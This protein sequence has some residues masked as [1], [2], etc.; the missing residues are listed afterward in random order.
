[1]IFIASLFVVS[2]G[3]DATG[4]T[5]W[6]GQALIARAGQSRTRLLVLMMLL[7]AVLTAL[8]SVNGAVAALLPVVAVM[9][10][11]LRMSPSQIL[12][13]LAFG[14]HAGSLV[15]LTGSPVNVIV[16]EYADDAG[17]GR[18]G[19]FEFAFV[20]IPLL[21][22]TI[23]IVVLFGERLLP[24]RKPRAMKRDFGDFARTLVDQYAL[25]DDP[26][27]LV[28]RQSGVA[29]VVVPPR[30]LLIGETVFPGMVTESGDL[31]V[32]A[33]QRKGEERSG[34][35][36]LAVGDTLLLQGSW[37]ALEYHLDD[38]DVLVVDDPAL[39][40]RQAVPLGPG[41]KQTLVILAGMVILL[42]TGRCLR[43]W[44][45]CSLRAR[46]CSQGCSPS[47]RHT[48]GSPGRPSSSSA[49]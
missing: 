37:G 15:A 30:S 4:V 12:M 35:T 14:A 11:R 17:V 26:D 20:G 9:A 3:L 42:A 1:M 8:I 48:A 24:I 22:G 5:A 19:F 6:A 32:L 46:S 23:A 34:E 39:V 49:G 25:D 41:A 38:P 10:V 16:S 2:E 31:V 18:F 47:T 28:S 29:E 33:V 27:T 44:P 43:R 36:E 21:A 7:V 13:P 45:G 40:R